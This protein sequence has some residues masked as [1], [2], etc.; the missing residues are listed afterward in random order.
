MLTGR[1]PSRY[2]WGRPGLGGLGLGYSTLVTDMAQ[3]IAQFEGFTSGASSIAVRNN[4]PGNLRAGVGQ[5]GTS[6]GYAVF[7]DLATGWAALDNQIQLNINKG[8]TLEE[9]FAGKPGVYPG[10][11]PQADSNNPNQYAAFVASQLG[12]DPNTPLSDLVSGNTDSTG[13][14]TGDQSTGGSAGSGSGGAGGDTSGDTLPASSVA[15]G[16]DNSDDDGGEGT[17]GTPEIL[18]LAGGVLLLIYALT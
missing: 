3:S 14:S 2:R 4:N 5:T 1:I 6:G 9:F 7:P 18:A 17:I 12:I 10:Y 8:L 13:Q 16:T 15:Q 11:A